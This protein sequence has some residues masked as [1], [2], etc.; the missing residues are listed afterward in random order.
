M[1]I[2]LGKSEK[3]RDRL[4]EEGGLFLDFGR[5]GLGVEDLVVGAVDLWDFGRKPPLTEALE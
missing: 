1:G 2:A 3:G 4:L 5:K